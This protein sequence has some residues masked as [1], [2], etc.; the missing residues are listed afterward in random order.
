MTTALWLRKM[1]TLM[2]L[3]ERY[4]GIFCT[5]VATFFKS[6]IISKLKVKKMLRVGGTILENGGNVQLLA[7]RKMRKRKWQKCAYFIV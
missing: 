1:L 4:T 6:E 5:A 7:R 2:N 3:S